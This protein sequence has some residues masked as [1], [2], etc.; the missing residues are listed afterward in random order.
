VLLPHRLLVHEVLEGGED[1]IVSD[2]FVMLPGVTRLEAGEVREIVLRA[3]P[4][5]LIEHTTI[6]RSTVQTEQQVRRLPAV[7][8]P[9]V[10]EQLTRAG[11]N[12]GQLTAAIESCTTDAELGSIAYLL[13]HMP[14]RD[15]TSLEADFL[16]DHL[17]GALRAR[18]ESRFCRDLPEEIFLNEVLPYAFVGERRERW[19]E[20]LRER[21]L[22]LVQSAPDQQAAVK[23]LNKKVWSDFGIKY[24]ATKR[25]RTDQCPSETIDCGI[26]SCTGL[27]IILGDACRAVGIPA[28]LAGV[29]MW[30]NDTGN[31]TWI[32]VWD[33]GAWHFV[34]ALGSD[35]YDRAWWTDHARKARAE[36]PLYAVWAT[37]YRP[38]G[39]HFPLEWDPDDMTIPAVN[40]TERYLD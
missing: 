21:Y 10:R 31:H 9:R 23:L 13:A 19:R 15:L 11:A 38:T 14:E 32:E 28:R 5:Q 18:A 33:D 39:S 35:G 36:D 34:E 8:R 7:H 3:D 6:E 16:L 4:R 26:A 1:L 22:E 20:P 29:P 37:T 25:P 24:H 12:R 2:T 30:H 27:S 40:V 17:R